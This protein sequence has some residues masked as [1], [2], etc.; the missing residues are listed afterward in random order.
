MYV[1]IQFTT[2]FF[3]KIVDVLL[4]ELNW[5][6]IIFLLNVITQL[7]SVIAKQDTWNQNRYVICVMMV[8]II[9]MEFV[10]IVTVTAMELI[11]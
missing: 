4:M 7:E 9:L 8:T 10:M 6:M 11:L 2:Q 3:F 5:M 1:Q